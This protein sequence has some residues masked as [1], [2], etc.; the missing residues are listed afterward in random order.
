ML[1]AAGTQLCCALLRADNVLQCL[2][3][4]RSIAGIEELAGVANHF[5]YGAAG[6]A[7]DRAVM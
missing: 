4:C 2:C 3:D 5:G 1:P 6:T 7:Y